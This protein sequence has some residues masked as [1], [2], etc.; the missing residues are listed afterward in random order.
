MWVSHYRCQSQRSGTT[1][2]IISCLSFTW[3]I[4][5]CWFGKGS[6]LWTSGASLKREADQ[7][8][9][10]WGFLKDFENAEYEKIR[11]LC[12]DYIFTWQ[13]VP[14]ISVLSSQCHLL[15]VSVLTLECLN[16]DP[17]DHHSCFVSPGLLNSWSVF[18]FWLSSLVTKTKNGTA[19]F[20]LILWLD[21]WG[22]SFLASTGFDR[23]KKKKNSF[24]CTCSD[25]QEGFGGK[26]LTHSKQPLKINLSEV[27]GGKQ[28]GPRIGQKWKIES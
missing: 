25:L 16:S 3:A 19:C 4:T 12:P 26:I 22:W 18:F 14:V 28:D 10:C 6:F 8:P 17:S 15:S 23:Q 9:A 24:K 13:H 5:W 27:Y 21:D 7:R 2:G 1:L 20:V 11:M